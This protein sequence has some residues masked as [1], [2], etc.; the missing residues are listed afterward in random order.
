[1][2]WWG[3]IARVY[4]SAMASSEDSAPSAGVAGRAVRAVREGFH[5]HD[6]APSPALDPSGAASVGAQVKLQLDLHFPMA[7]AEDP[8]EETTWLALGGQVGEILGPDRVRVDGLVATTDRAPR[9][10]AGAWIAE[11]VRQPGANFPWM[12]AA[13]RP[14]GGDLGCGA[15]DE[16]RILFKIAC[17]G[18]APRVAGF[19]GALAAVLGGSADDGSVLMSMTVRDWHVEFVVCA[20]V[21]DHADAD[22]EQEL[23]LAGA[24]AVLFATGDPVTQAAVRARLARQE[25]SLDALVHAVCDAPPLEMMKRVA[26]DLLLRSRL[27]R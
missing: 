3:V 27:S 5:R 25:R 14:A 22:A 11:L 1:M 12:L 10:F 17:T 15:I 8:D 21:G 7:C 26:K 6:K 19:L 16:Q 2:G 24:D 18:D 23:L 20:A 13:L 9:A 4:S